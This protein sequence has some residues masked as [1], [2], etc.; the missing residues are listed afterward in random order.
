MS[1]N[2]TNEENTKKTVGFK[3]SPKLVH[4]NTMCSNNIHK[5]YMS[6]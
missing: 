6:K 5:Y 1:E 2:V 4:M 3:V